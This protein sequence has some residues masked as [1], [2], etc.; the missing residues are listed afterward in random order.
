[1][2]K[3]TEEDLDRSA[4]Q[5]EET[6]RKA[7]EMAQKVCGMQDDVDGLLRQYGINGDKMSAFVKGGQLTPEQR[8]LVQKEE[9]E[10]ERDL[11]RDKQVAEEQFRQG[12]SGAGQKKS[13]PRR[14]R[15]M[16]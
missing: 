9:E 5:V 8:A 12:Q 6:I 1:M 7:E 3:H 15:N 16:V 2:A 4:K 13:A 14:R 11:E 10:F